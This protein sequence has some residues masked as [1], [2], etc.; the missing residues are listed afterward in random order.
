M[1]PEGGSHPYETDENGV[2]LMLDQETNLCAVYKDRPLLCDLA[3]IY[4]EYPDVAES[5]SKWYI[6][7]MNACNFMM[8]IAGTPERFRIKK[9]Y[10]I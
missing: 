4:R 9:P 5:E 7:N 1:L 10:L 8:K 6:H 3:R 2:C